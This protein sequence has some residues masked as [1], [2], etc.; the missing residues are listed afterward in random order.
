MTVDNGGQLPFEKRLNT[1]APQVA[2][3][4]GQTLASRL[5]KDEFYPVVCSDCSTMVGVYDRDQNYYF[6]NVLPSNC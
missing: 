5:H 3:S 2:A 1:V 6:F 4:R